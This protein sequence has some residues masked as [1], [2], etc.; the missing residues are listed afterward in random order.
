METSVNDLCKRY[1]W[2]AHGGVFFT[3]P[4]SSKESG[5]KNT[6]DSMILCTPHPAQSATPSED[7]GQALSRKG[8]G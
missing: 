5:V 2:Q 3:P 1:P 6:P 8:R 4:S 7:S